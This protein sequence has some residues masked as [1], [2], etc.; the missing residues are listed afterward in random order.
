MKYKQ[1]LKNLRNLCL[2]PTLLKGKNPDLI[3]KSTFNDLAKTLLDR[4]IAE[5]AKSNNLGEMDFV[6][7]I[8]KSSDL[9]GWMYSK[10]GL[11][12]VS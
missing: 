10:C 2:V 9:P 7:E 5:T 3:L 6:V 1:I 12:S 4:L 11:L 8:P